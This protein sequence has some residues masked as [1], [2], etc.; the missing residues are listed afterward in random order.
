[1]RRAFTLVEL[2][3]VIAIIGILIALLLPAVQAAREAARRAQCANHLKQIGLAL[4]N[5]E[6][7]YRILPPLCVNSITSPGTNWSTSALLIPGPYQG[8]VGFTVFDHLLPFVEQQPLYDGSLGKVHNTV[9]GKQVVS[10]VIPTYLCPS[11]RDGSATTGMGATTN[12]GANGWAVGNYSANYFCFGDPTH[13]TTEGASRVPA[14]FPDGMSNVVFFTERYGTCSTS[15]VANS[16]TT[17]GNLWSDSNTVWRPVFCINSYA[18]TP[19]TDKYE[20]CLKF[21][22][23]PQW[24]TQCESRRAQSPHTSGIHVCLGD[25]SVRFLSESM[26]DNVWAMACD[27]QDGATLPADW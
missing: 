23:A 20:P 14:H 4:H 5:C 21:Q 11:A 16:A 1:M 7:T 25:G 6:N 19:T 24:L 12:G 26:A 2:L 13:K 22:V 15:G 17:Y 9:G 18:Q 8:K 10:H 27:P 3:V